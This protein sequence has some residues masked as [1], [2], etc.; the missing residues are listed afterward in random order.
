M[1]DESSDSLELSRSKRNERIDKLG[2]RPQKELFCNKFLPYADKLDDESQAILDNIKNNLGKAAAMR[3]I[4]PGVSIYVSRLM[5][6]IKLYGMKFSK[7]DHIKFVK[8]LLELICIPN[9]EPDKVN[10]FCYALTTL[11]RKPEWLSPDDLQI[12]WRP[13]YKLCNLILNKNCSKGDLYRY[14]AS[15]ETNLQFA[16]QYCNPYFPRSATQEILDEL[17]P[18]LQPLDTGKG[19]N[20]FGLLHIFLSGEHDYDLWFEKFMTIWNA[21]HNPPWS[22][23]MMILFAS[24]SYRNIGY[25]DWE[26]YIPTMFARILR[27]IDFPVSYKNTKSSKLQGLSPQSVALWIV[28]VLGPKSSAQQYLNK[29]MTTIESY[30]HPA[31]TGKWVS[32]LGEIL[33]H[34]PKYFFDRLILERYR[35]H[36]YRKPIPESHKLTDDCITAFVECMKPVTLQAMYSRLNPQDVGKIFQHLADLRPALIIPS[37]IDRVYASLDSLTEPHKMTAALHSLIYVSRAL[38]SGHNGYTEGKNHVIPLFFAMLPG[39]DPNDFRKTSITFNFLT[40]IAFLIPIID[41]SKAGQYHELNE[42]ERLLCEQT[43]DFEDFVLQYLDRIFLLIESNSLDNVRME[44]SDADSMRS[45]WE[46]IS[47]ALIQACSHG[48]LGQCSES[49]LNSA[50][51]KLIDFVK[52]RLLEPKVAG[53]MMGCLIRVFAR[54][55]GKEVQR[56]LMPYLVQTI[57]RYMEDHEDIAE[58]EKQSDEMLYYLLLLTNM[59]RG[60]PVE[61][62]KYVD[63]VLPILDRILKFKCKQANKY[64]STLLANLMSNLSTMQTLDVKNSPDS[65]EK[66]LSEILPIRCWGEKMPPDGKLKWYFPNEQALMVC[67][68]L[69][70]RYLIPIMDNFQKYSADKMELHRDDIN[71]DLVIILSL[72]RCS[73][74]LPNWDDEEPLPIY[75]STI[76]RHEMKWNVTRGFED[77]IIKMPDGQNVRKA[78]VKCITALQRKILEKSEDDVKSLKSIL[79][80]YDKIFVRKHSNALF[81]SQVKNFASTKKFQNYRLT[82]FKRDVRA[83]V[84]TRV[85]MQQDCRDELDQPLFTATHLEV[86]MNLFDLATSHY[87]SVRVTAQCKLFV[88]LSTFSFSYKYL[89]DRIVDSLQLD[90]NKNHE[91]FKGILYILIVNRRSRL[92]I[93]HDWEFISRIWVALLKSKLSEKPSIVKLL[94]AITE[95][96]KNEFPTVSTE[97]EVSDVCVECGLA[98]RTREDVLDL[99]SGRMARAAK[100]SKNVQMYYDLIAQILS[101]VENDK[102]HWRYNYLASSMLYNLVHPLTKF[103]ASVAQFAV[104]NLIHDSIDDRKQAI[105]LLNHVLRQQ[106]REHLKVAANPYEIAG[107]PEKAPVHGS[108][109]QPGYREDNL[110]L[111][112]DVE[113]LPKSQEEWDQP[114]YVY[115]M[116]GYFGWSSDFSVYAPSKDQPKLDRTLE[117]MNEHEQ[118]IFNFFNKQEN[119]DKL[120]KFWSLEEKKGRDKFNR[121]RFCLIKGLMNAF[122]D[123]FLDKFVKHLRP[124]IEDKA[125]ESNHRC[126]AEIMA[127]IMRG[128][129]HWPYSK[130]ES[131]YESLVPLIR[132]ALNNV[133]VDTDGYWGTCF[134]TGVEF[135]DPSKQY[136]LHEILLENPLQESTSF[137]DCNRLYCLQG[138]FNQHVW[139]M[140]TVA[141]RLLEY[142]RPY[143]DHSFQNVRERIGSTLINIFEADLR[144][145]GNQGLELSPKIKEM[146]AYVMPKLS[147]LLNEEDASAGKMDIESEEGSCSKRQDTEHETAVRLFKT[148]AQWLTSLINRCS[149]GNEIEYF[150]L[151]PIVCRLERSEQDQELAEICSTLLAMISQALTLPPCMDA[152]LAKIDQISKMSS[153]SARRSVIDVLQVLVFY[154]MTII[155]SNEKWKT[156]TQD[157]V[158]RLLEDSVVEVREKAAEVLCGLLHCSF[159]TATEELLELFKDKC[160][161]RMMR[162]KRLKITPSCSSAVLKNDGGEANAVRARHTGVLGLCAFISAYPYEVPE[163]VPN[164]FEHL[165]AHLNDPQPIPATIRK[166]LGDFKR[167]HH[168]NWELHQL[169]FTEDQLAVLSD[170]TIPPSYYA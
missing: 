156:K 81:D 122:G 23:D 4:T 164:V 17:L 149:N 116:D 82:K 126:S 120:I 135:I 65:F 127:G 49:I 123:L 169:K 67:S 147:V 75:E 109:V 159:L 34:L 16:I 150:D 108:S 146:I 55:H 154:N 115:K 148:V 140:T 36:P 83:I 47:E 98:L 77:L 20:T 152:A 5:K 40:S 42:E 26:P 170:L 14:F 72:V 117:E 142:L 30:L 166:T 78:I 103:P 70:H 97:L 12:E 56:S 10:R 38:V 101:T 88:L 61:I 54:I 91:A 110:W 64:G 76:D 90:S 163:F 128:A 107:C 2:F 15:L 112:Y 153:W 161:T 37:I 105:K 53:Q 32:M 111:Q 132:L 133:T 85:I 151:L 1:D 158:L 138:A 121:N 87:S 22:I 119:I 95:V 66:P 143:L 24:A 68:K 84:A 125:S 62:V 136:W 29:F 168:D 145:Q 19:F 71:R 63:D 131:M 13:L 57:E 33:I 114:R 155:L 8:L 102:L 28:S 165:G 139:R 46:S 58:V 129:K 130:T 144:F 21:Y 100:N 92:V 45:K 69:L 3:E 43:A 157:I 86:L 52:T 25:I 137:I 18:K 124:L 93:K 74:F 106:K 167:T 89:T 27:S 31:N 162:T 39:I 99:E 35:K 41:C 60:D 134:A 50:S 11:L 73:N 6:Y 7:E 80:L 9:L 118:V 96:I 104:N 160:R 113:K 94:D 59:M 79:Q 51:R 48:I 141:K 44:Q